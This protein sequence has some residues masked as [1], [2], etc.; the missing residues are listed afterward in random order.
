M[1]RKFLEDLGLEKDV[2]DK[3]MSENGKDIESA[4]HRLEVERDNYK[5]SLETAQNALKEFE[6]V[7]VK[8]LN[9]KITQLTADL[10]KKD[11]DYQAKIAEME[12]NTI[13][14]NAIASSGAK[15]TKAV[16]ALL[17]LGTL[18]ASK[19]QTED[20]KNA[21]DSVKAENDYMFGSAEPIDGIVT[22][23]GKNKNSGI[24]K[25]M[26]AKMGYGERLKLKQTDPNKYK[27]LKG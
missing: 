17:D 25:E 14:D 16:K 13:V 19:N 8:E 18:K 12:F 26:F 7:D 21:L 10:E 27:E 4:K 15:N 11:S 22:D 24:T 9:G 2:I 5:D 3:I 20:I 1:Q 23:T 6:G